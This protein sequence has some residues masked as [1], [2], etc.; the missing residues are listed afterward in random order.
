[1]AINFDYYK[2]IKPVIDYLKLNFGE[3]YFVLKLMKV[4]S[5]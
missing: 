1:M 3:K 4:S 2:L 5:V